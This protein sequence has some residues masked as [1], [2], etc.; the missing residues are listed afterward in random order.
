MEAR[1][2]VVGGGLIGL[3]ITAALA[4][5]GMEVLL[6]DELLPGS[7]SQASAGMLAPSVERTE[8]PAHD[9]AI[10][11]R[12]R[13]PSF[14]A[15]LER[16]TGIAIPLNRRGVLQIALNRRAVRSLRAGARGNTRWIETDELTAL[17]PAL[18]HAMGAAF[19]PD[20][21]AVDNVVLLEALVSLTTR[22]S[23]VTRVVDR[24]VT[25]DSWGTGLKLLTGRGME[26]AS[27]TVVLS[28]GAW[29]GLIGGASHAQCITPVRGQIL[30]FV[31][32][33]VSRVVY[34]PRG[35]LVPRERGH[36]LAGS[37]MENVGFD[38]STTNDGLTRIRSAAEEI[39]PALG[40]PSQANGWAGLRPVTPDLL[41]LLGWDPSVRGLIHAS[42]HSRN[43]VLLA[44]M[45]ADV[46]ADLVTGQR[47]EWDLSQFR[48]DRF[49][50]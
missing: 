43:G 8:G 49:R 29:S 41:P 18:G 12:D 19:S 16:E 6:V 33:P 26:I 24:V 7:A 48:P 11:S 32:A 17:E 38:A 46:V 20:D 10:A 40:G 42:G 30:S 44:P 1:I 34:G 4:H 36:T 14:V 27:D 9:F 37:T 21:G 2:T 47:V 13:F 45:T 39:C 22:S 5:R 35:Y 23:L 25:I 28:A 31:G 15:D 50:C 3:S